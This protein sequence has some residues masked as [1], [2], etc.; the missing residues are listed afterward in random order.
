MKVF[1]RMKS[2][3]KHRDA[4]EKREYELPERISTLRQLIVS[5]V[6]MEV[7]AYNSKGAEAAVTRFL[8]EA[9]IE[10]DGQRGKIGF[11]RIYSDKK[12]D[13]E[14]ARTVALQ[15][16]ADG[17]FRVFVNE[18]ERSGLEEAA[19]VSEGDTLTFVRFAFLSGRLW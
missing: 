19:D 8:T 6:D 2:A 17:L 5:V 3:G 10:N 16:Y 1:V 7:A 9:E 11:D 13:R 15:A 12:A 18:S 4:L 14:K